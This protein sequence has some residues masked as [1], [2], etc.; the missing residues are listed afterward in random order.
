MATHNITHFTSTADKMSNHKEDMIMKG[1]EGG[2]HD[3]IQS[4]E[5][6]GKQK[7]FGHASK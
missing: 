5:D 6:D 7:T 4:K 3:L 2:S 1:F